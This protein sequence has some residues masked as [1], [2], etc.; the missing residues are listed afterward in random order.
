M[1][2]PLKHSHKWAITFARAKG[3]AAAA[4]SLYAKGDAEGAKAELDL[5]VNGDMRDP[6][7]VFPG[8]KIAGAYWRAVEGE[9][10]LRFDVLYE[11]CEW[12]EAVG[13]AEYRDG[14]ERYYRM[15][16]ADVAEL[17]ADGS[18]LPYEAFAPYAESYETAR[19][20]EGWIPLYQDLCARS[21]AAL[22]EG[23]FDD[24]LLRDWFTFCLRGVVAYDYGLIRQGVLS[25]LLIER[26]GFER[27]KRIVDA[28][29]EE[30]GWRVTKLF[31]ADMYP[32]AGIDGMALR[33]LGRYGMFADQDLVTTER[34]AAA[35]K[36]DVDP[37]W[38]FTEFFNCE[39]RGIF[40]VVS[41]ES[42]IPLSELGLGVCVYCHE[43]ARKTASLFT[44]PDK[45]PSTNMVRALG[46]GGESCL[47]ETE[48]RPADDMERFMEAQDRVFYS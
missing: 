29:G 39:E 44:P 41:A 20:G 15:F 30:F 7:D 32:K 6:R 4:D 37:S 10:N 9:M 28:S 14:V 40:E 24:A 38:R 22:A 11:Y 36:E 13:E 3:Y 45:H 33:Q 23:R 19:L 8:L 46:L 42:G 47:F 43:H 2:F 12:P 17:L 27:L 35:G 26:R 1:N 34:N 25:R 31:F 18:L 48:I 5:L 21:D 16:L